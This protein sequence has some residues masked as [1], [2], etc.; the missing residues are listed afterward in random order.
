MKLNTS[1][2]FTLDEEISETTK[3]NITNEDAGALNIFWKG[4]DSTKKQEVEIYKGFST[5]PSDLIYKS[6]KLSN[7]EHNYSFKVTKNSKN[8]L[9]Y[10]SYDDMNKRIIYFELTHSLGKE[11]GF[12]NEYYKNNWIIYSSGTYKFYTKIDSNEQGFNNII[13]AYRYNLKNNSYDSISSIKFSYLD[14]NESPIKELKIERNVYHK[15]TDS[16]NVTYYYF[17]LD[18]DIYSIVKSDDLYYIQVEF[19][20]EFKDEKGPYSLDE[21]SFERVQ[22]KKIEDKKWN[23]KL[24]DLIKENNGELGIYYFDE[25]KIIFEQN[26]NI[27]FYTNAKDLS[28]ILYYGN[29]LDFSLNKDDINKSSFE[30]VKKLFVFTKETRNQ[31]KIKNDNNVI[32]L[33]ID[34][35]NFNGKIISDNEFL[36]FK[37]QDASQNIITFNENG[38][39]SDIFKQEELYSIDNENDCSKTNYFITYYSAEESEKTKICFSKNIYGVIDFY[40]INQN[41]IFSDKVGGVEDILPDKNGFSINEHPYEIMNGE[42]EIF[43]ISCKKYPA[44]VKFYSFDNEDKDEKIGFLGYNNKFIGFIYPE[45]SDRLEKTY[46]FNNYGSEIFKPCQLQIIKI[47]GLTGVQIKYKKKASDEF[48]DIKEGE[49]RILDSYEDS[50]TFKILSFY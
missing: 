12:K 27:L 42:L 22:V 34:Q 4:S 8:L 49:K 29:F 47:T 33:I 17:T 44:L 2:H 1:Q 20:F 6:V 32:V 50:P 39:R 28:G 46:L 16:K 15:Y 25:K 19:I 48:S 10:T 26:Q 36:E 43:A 14:I 38:I 7:Y 31:Y 37:L 5:N 21:L 30:I 35:N 41:L 13:N 24:K 45:N 9:K 23:K 11:F 18:D 40:Y 3:Y